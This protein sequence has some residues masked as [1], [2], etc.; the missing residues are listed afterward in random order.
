MRKGSILHFTPGK[1]YVP[2]ADRTDKAREFDRHKA[3]EP[4]QIKVDMEFVKKLSNRV[5]DGK[6][7][8]EDIDTRKSGLIREQIAKKG[9]VEIPFENI[10]G[11]AVTTLTSVFL[12]TIN[13]NTQSFVLEPKEK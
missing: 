1:H 8:I 12:L 11:E 7:L 13:G 6:P 10:T 3:A 4:R 5:A 9:Y 2:P